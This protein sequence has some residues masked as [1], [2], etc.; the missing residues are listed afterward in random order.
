MQ[1]HRNTFDADILIHNTQY[2]EGIDGVKYGIINYHC[3]SVWV[4]NKL[5]AQRWIKLTESVKTMFEVQLAL[6]ELSIFASQVVEMTVCG[7]N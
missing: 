7:Q 3:R 1:Q 5:Q 6:V 2:N 4:S